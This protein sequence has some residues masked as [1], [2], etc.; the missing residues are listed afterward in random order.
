MNGMTFNHTR[1][2][3]FQMSIGGAK[4][5]IHSRVSDGPS[6]SSGAGHVFIPSMSASCMDSKSYSVLA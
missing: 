2:A 6:I 3:R 1:V 5:C 4:G